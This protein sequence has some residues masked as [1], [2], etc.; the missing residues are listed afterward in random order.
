LTCAGGL[1][2][3]SDLTPGTA[4]ATNDLGAPKFSQVHVSG[5]TAVVTY[6]SSEINGLLAHS[7]V[8]L[9]RT[10]GRWLA[11]KATALTFT[12]S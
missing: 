12:H 3:L 6:T 10:S 5:N 4:R 8:T 1:K 11:D 9:E 2:F 7:T